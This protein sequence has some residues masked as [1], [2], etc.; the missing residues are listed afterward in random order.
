MAQDGDDLENAMAY[1]EKQVAQNDS[2][3]GFSHKGQAYQ[4]G[5]GYPVQTMKEKAA[6]P[7]NYPKVQ[8]T[9]ESDT[10][11]SKTNSRED[12]RPYEQGMPTG[13]KRMLPRYRKGFNPNTPK[14]D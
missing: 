7:K 4:E 5:D 1:L 10:D 12:E 8:V 3:K 2:V 13:I 6:N 14:G 11:L 9:K